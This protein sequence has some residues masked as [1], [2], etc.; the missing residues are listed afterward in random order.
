MKHGRKTR[1]FNKEWRRKTKCWS[2]GCWI[3]RASSR[4]FLSQFIY[5]TARHRYV[6]ACMEDFLTD[7]L[8]ILQNPEYICAVNLSREWSE[9]TVVS[10]W[11]QTNER[12]IYLWP[13]HCWLGV[14]CS[15]WRLWFSVNTER[16]AVS[17]SAGIWWW[18]KVLDTWNADLTMALRRY[19][20]WEPWMSCREHLNEMFHFI[21]SEEKSEDHHS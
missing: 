4:L 1:T 16:T 2:A 10:L 7:Q 6:L 21:S 15:H 20:L 18:T 13:H 5:F 12:H 3:S 8:M 19:V 11:L 17:S 14:T 9:Y